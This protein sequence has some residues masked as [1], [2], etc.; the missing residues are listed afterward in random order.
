[1]T[2]DEQIQKTMELCDRL[3]PIIDRSLRRLVTEHGL[4][5]STSVITNLA[6]GM[7]VQAMLLA[8]SMGADADQVHDVIAKESREQFEVF[9]S[10]YEAK[11]L[12][13]RAMSS[14]TCSPTKH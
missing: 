7:T 9:H 5:V 8:D 3:H 11:D 2:E 6:V 1:M 13:A 12:L 4:A 10:H 14:P